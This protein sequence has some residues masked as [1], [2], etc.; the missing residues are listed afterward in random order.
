DRSRAGIPVS[1]A[2]AVALIAP[3]RAA[4]AVPGAAQSF[5]LQLHQALG[6]KADHLAQECRIGALLQKRSKGDLVVG[7]RGDPQIRVA[8]RNPTL[9]RIATV[10]ADRPACARLLAVAPAGRSAASYTIT[11]DTTKSDAAV[12]IVKCCN[13]PHRS[14]FR[15]AYCERLLRQPF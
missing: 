7:H 14:G 10:A 13:H 5:A 15:L 6:S 8:C 9:L 3:F 1:V 12:D 11:R 4:L 2:V